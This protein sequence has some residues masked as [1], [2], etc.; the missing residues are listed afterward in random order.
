MSSIALRYVR[1]AGACVLVLVAQHALAQSHGITGVVRDPQQ[2]VV[3]GAEVV[4][5]NSR[6]AA[7]ATAVTDGQGRYTFALPVPD[8]YVV[9]VHAKGFVVTTTEAI[10]LA[11]CR[12]F[13]KSRP[14]RASSS[15]TS[16][17]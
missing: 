6:T 5:I 14:S 17:R 1:V 12:Q 7:R 11:H 16:S 2:A 9:E 15:Q 8:S 13:D 10:A 4:L 3:V